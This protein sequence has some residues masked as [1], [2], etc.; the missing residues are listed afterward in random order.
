MGLVV[1]VWDP[2]TQEV[3]GRRI[4]NQELPEELSF[5]KLKN[6]IKCKGLLGWIPQPHAAVIRSLGRQRQENQE[7]FLLLR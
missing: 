3:L 4:I 1:H 2:S 6:K 7:F 5:S